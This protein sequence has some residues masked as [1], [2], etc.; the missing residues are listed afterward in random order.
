M[1]KQLTQL[2]TMQ[3]QHIQE[4]EKRI[5]VLRQTITLQ[6]KQ[7][8]EVQARSERRRIELCKQIE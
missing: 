7:L 2:N 1:I 8:K 3:S 4:L 6:D 5:E